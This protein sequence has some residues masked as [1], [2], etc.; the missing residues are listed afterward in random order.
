VQDH[1]RGIDKKVLGKIGTPFLTTKENGTGLGLAICF[2]IAS[3]HNAEINEDT[4]PNR[5]HLF[6]PV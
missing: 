4:R 5:D 2:S 6:C 3:R 1:G